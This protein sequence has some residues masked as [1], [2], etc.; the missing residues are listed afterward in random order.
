[1]SKLEAEVKRFL[2]ARG[3]DTLRPSDLAKSIIIEAAEL[4]E[5]FQWKS[6]TIEETKENADDMK[7][8]RKELADVLI[9]CLELAVLLGLDVETIIMEKLAH[10]DKKYPAD[11]IRKARE[12]EPGT[13]DVYQQIKA[14]YRRKGLS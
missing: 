8:I 9:Y 11:V 3:W 6:R 14:N 7:N 10:T 13:T 2:E 4:L 1:M 12:A 5:I